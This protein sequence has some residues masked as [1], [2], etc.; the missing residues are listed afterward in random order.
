VLVTLQGA[1]ILIHAVASS[2]LESNLTSKSILDTLMAS[3]AVHQ[4]F[5]YMGCAALRGEMT[6]FNVYQSESAAIYYSRRARC[7]NSMW[8]IKAVSIQ[9][10]TSPQCIGDGKAGCGEKLALGT[11]SWRKPV[12]QV[13]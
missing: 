13:P 3:G 8:G 4:R 7:N 1:T 11:P 10:S 6:L 2:E 12:A 9:L 5:A